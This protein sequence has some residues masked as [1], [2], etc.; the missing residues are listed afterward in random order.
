MPSAAFRRLAQTITNGG[1]E[2]HY[3]GDFDWAPVAVAATLIDRG[4][5]TPWRMTAADYLAGAGAARLAL[6]GAP[7]PTPWDPGLAVAMRQAGLVV[8]EESV[9]DQLIGDLR[10]NVTRWLMTVE[11]QF[12]AG[13]GG[14]KRSSTSAIRFKSA[15]W[16]LKSV[17]SW[18]WRRPCSRRMA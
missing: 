4:Q 12:A 2:L 15:S 9:A 1:G 14:A 17:G 8:P 11:I 13:S 7:Q 5:A 18:A 16:L 10:Q 6:T 3:H